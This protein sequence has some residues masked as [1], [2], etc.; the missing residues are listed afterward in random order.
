MMQFIMHFCAVSSYFC[1][2]FAHTSSSTSF[3]RD[4]RFTDFP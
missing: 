2:R 3:S 4:P 1:P